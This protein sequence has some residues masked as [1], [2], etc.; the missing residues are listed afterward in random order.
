MESIIKPNTARLQA[1]NK[2]I[3]FQKELSLRGVNITT[4]YCLQQR[5]VAWVKHELN[6]PPNITWGH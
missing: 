5:I 3:A 1:K 4:N 2:S 6:S